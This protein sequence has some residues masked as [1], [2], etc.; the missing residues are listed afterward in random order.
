MLLTHTVRVTRRKAHAVVRVAIRI[1]PALPAH[2]DA[3]AVRVFIDVLG[4]Y[5][6]RLGH[7][8][9]RVRMSLHQNVVDVVVLVGERAQQ[10]RNRLSN[11][12][13]FATL[14]IIHVER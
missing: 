5:V 11:R 2:V 14:N 12:R 3:H 9:R 7:S 6:A 1:R 13:L 4:Q 8:G 10:L